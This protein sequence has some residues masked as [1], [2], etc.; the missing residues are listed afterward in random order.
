[1]EVQEN[2]I[3]DK[4]LQFAVRIIKMCRYLRNE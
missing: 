4:S 2:V 3:Q 1:M